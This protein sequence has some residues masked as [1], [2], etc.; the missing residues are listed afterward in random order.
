MVWCVD[1]HL[2]SLHIYRK[3]GRLLSQLLGDIF[4]VHVQVM[5]QVA[6]HIRVLNVATDL[7]RARAARRVNVDVHRGVTVSAPADV[8]AERNHGGQDLERGFGV[9]CQG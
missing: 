5:A 7:I 1:A 3:L 9:V 4:D 2:T 6:T 8:S